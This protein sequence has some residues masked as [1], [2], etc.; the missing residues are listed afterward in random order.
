LVSNII[1][2]YGNVFFNYHTPNMQIK[3]KDLS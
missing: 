2:F 3:L 1:G